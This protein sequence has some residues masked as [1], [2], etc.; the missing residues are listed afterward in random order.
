MEDAT[1]LQISQGMSEKEKHL[2]SKLSQVYYDT[3]G[4]MAKE[5]VYY[6]NY[7]TQQFPSL[8][9]GGQGIVLQVNATDLSRQ[10]RVRLVLP[11]IPA[12]VSLPKGWGYH[13]IQR[14]EY[15]YASSTTLN[16]DGE[17]H[18]LSVMS[19]CETANKRDELMD[20]GGEEVFASTGTVQP[21]AVVFIQLPHSRVRQ[22]IASKPMDNSLLSQ[23]GYQIVLYLKP[24]SQIMGG[25]GAS[26]W[27]ASNNS[28]ISA[29]WQ[30]ETGRIFDQADSIRGELMADPRL[31][32]C[33]PFIYQQPFTTTFTGAVS[34]QRAQVQLNG[35]RSGE[36]LS[37]LFAVAS[38]DDINGDGTV[39]GVKNALNNLDPLTNIRLTLNG[40]VLFDL[41]G[42]SHRL[43][44]SY[45]SIDSSYFPANA[46]TPLT[47]TAS[48]FASLPVKCYFVE[49]DLATESPKNFEGTRLTGL[50]DVGN[51][52]IN[53]EFSTA[54]SGQYKLFAIYSYNSCIEIKNGTASFVF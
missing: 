53:L 43:V 12:N 23:G 13:M 27:L 18:L 37:I 8:V 41:E 25:S 39:G 52:V 17:Q 33:Y 36:L 40:N 4:V 7:Y 14:I 30:V 1:P 34:P 28:F 44:G 49:L 21:E 10:V 20:L 5:D 35:F 2:G 16:L 9:L 31:S 24:L 47:Q 11:A 46:F 42:K 6:G 15:R 54:T 22:L 45:K 50:R 29:Q 32:Y 3:T 19:A 26:A 51:S 38:L 48:P